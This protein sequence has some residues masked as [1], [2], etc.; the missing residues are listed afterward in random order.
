VFYVSFMFL[1]FY[2]SMFLSLSLEIQKLVVFEFFKLKMSNIY[3]MKLNIKILFFHPKVFCKIRFWTFL[4]L[5]I[6]DFC[7]KVLKK[8]VKKSL[9]VSY[10]V[11]DF[12]NSKKNVTIIFLD[13]FQKMDNF[14]KWTK[15]I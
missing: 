12:K 4:N 10:G 11:I 8:R 5:S 1:C 2:V 9:M 15:K 13:I 3:F 7:E 14:Q 6:F